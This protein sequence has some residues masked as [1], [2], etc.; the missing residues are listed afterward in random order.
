MRRALGICS[1]AVLPGGALGKVPAEQ[2]ELGIPVSTS[3]TGIQTNEMILEVNYNIP[4]LSRRGFPSGV[5]IHRLAERAI[6]HSQRAAF[7]LNRSA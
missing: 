2:L 1:A 3:A 7:S 5:P 6:D 4:C